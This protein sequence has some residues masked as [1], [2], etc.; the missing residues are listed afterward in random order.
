ME[1]LGRVRHWGNR[2]DS[3][4]SLLLFKFIVYWG[5]HTHG[6][7]ITKQGGTLYTN[8]VM[9]TDTSSDGALRRGPCHLVVEGRA[10]VPGRL[11]EEVT[12]G[13]VHL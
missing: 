3:Y 6:G 2:D 7:V 11:Y 4:T 5:S 9:D 8:T 10:G 1:D 13:L 12:F